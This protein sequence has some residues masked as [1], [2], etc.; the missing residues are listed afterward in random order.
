[1]SAT[2]LR[3]LCH[4]QHFTGVGHFVI[5]HNLA[6]GLAEHH[7]VF[8]TDGGRAVPR[9]TAA[10]EPQRVEL[11]I[12]E[13]AP[14]G[15]LF[16]ESGE[17]PDAVLARRADV[18]ADATTAIRPDVVLVDHYPF[19]K[20]ELH[21]EITAAIDAARRANPDVVVLSSLRDISPRTRYEHMSDAEHAARVCGLLGS[22]F[23]GLLVH[24]DPAFVRLEEHFPG[25]AD[26]PVPVTYTAFVTEAPVTTSP[27]H[28]ESAGPTPSPADAPWAVL[29]G[30]GADST[31]FRATA[32]TAFSRLAAAGSLGRMRLHVFCGLVTHPDDQTAL[33]REAAAGPVEIHSFSPTFAAWLDGAAMSISRAGYNTTAALLAARVRAVVVPGG[34][35]SDQRLRAQRLARAG[36]AV[37]VDADQEHNVSALSDAIETALAEPRPAHHFDLD[38]VGATRRVVEKMVRGR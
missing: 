37:V 17:R 28:A 19:S 2:R 13:R 24:V 16:A 31:R 15:S 8:L 33:E 30:G 35:V 23:E 38:G 3:I 6:R 32:T 14:D 4:A 7:D 22:S 27:V 1:M 21:R 20:W 29:S 9:P 5:A 25:A 10:V 36:L 34:R 12:M 18:L 26:I 11:P